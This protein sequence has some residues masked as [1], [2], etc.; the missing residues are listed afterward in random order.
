LLPECAANHV[1]PI[2]VL[3]FIFFSRICCESW[4]PPECAENHCFS[5]N[6]LSVLFFPY[7][8]LLI[9]IFFRMFLQSCISRRICCHFRFFPECAATHVIFPECTANHVFPRMCC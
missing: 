6:V 3:L 1:V 2:N 7:N 9:M 5:Q 4:F 8:L